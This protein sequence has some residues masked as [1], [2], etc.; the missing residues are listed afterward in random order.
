MKKLSSILTILVIIPSVAIILTA[1]VIGDCRL[2]VFMNRAISNPLLDIL[3]AYASPVAFVAFYL[4]SMA[5]LCFFGGNMTIAGGGISGVTG[6]VAYG[7]GSL[8]K[9]LVGRPRPYVVVPSA[10]VI[11]PWSTSSF[12]FPSTTTMLVFGLT[13][14]LLLIS[15]KRSYGVILLVLSYFVGFSV[16]Y[17]GFHFPTDV[18]AGALLSLGLGI[19]MSE[20]V[21]RKKVHVVKDVQRV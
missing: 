20:I 21:R 14:P 11:G 1:S 9:A 4:F 12:S 16:I 3:C 8:A 15:Q 19:S 5:K 2:F 17:T 7:V 13:I 6:L 10:R 18:A